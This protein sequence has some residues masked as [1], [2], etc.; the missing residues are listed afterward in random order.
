MKKL[1]PT[2][3]IRRAMVEK[4]NSSVE[5]ND[6]DVER[7]RLTKKYGTVWDTRELQEGFKVTGF[8]APFCVVIQKSTG[9]KGMVEFQHQP[10]LYFN[11]QEI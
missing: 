5:T 11:F 1:D 6:V 4:I 7:E 10:R 9:K 8:A 3:N 2:E